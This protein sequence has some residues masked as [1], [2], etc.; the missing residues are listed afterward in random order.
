MSQLTG[1]KYK[2]IFINITVKHLL[3]D[4]FQLTLRQVIE[5]EVIFQ[6]INYQSRVM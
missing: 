2:T 3:F 1:L 6:A 5:D 4:I